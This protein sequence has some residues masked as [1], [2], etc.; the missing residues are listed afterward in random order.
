MTTVQLSESAGLTQYQI[1]LFLESGLIQAA[2]VGISGGG[3]RFEFDAG[4]L[5][6]ARLL[7]Q[8]RLKGVPLS[9][10]ATSDLSFDGEAYLVF[11]GDRLRA[12]KD[13]AAAIGAVVKAKRWC[14]AVDL[15]SI[16]TVAAE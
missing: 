8:L 9:R 15:A 12:C 16:R 7:K 11:N 1:Q 6:R 5:Q 10:L 4:Q 3:R 13:A 14:S 2:T